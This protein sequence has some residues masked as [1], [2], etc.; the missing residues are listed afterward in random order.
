MANDNEKK[1]GFE[2]INLYDEETV[3]NAKEDKNLSGDSIADNGYTASSSDIT[4]KSKKK[5]TKDEEPF[6]LKKEIF[7]YIKIILCAIV[8]AL[9]FN[10]FIIVN[11]SVPS[12]SMES[13]IM[14]G[15]KISGNRLSYKFSEP[16]RGDIIIFKFPDNEEENYI[17]RIIG[18]P[19]DIIE[20]TNGIVYINGE[21]LDESYLPAHPYM[22]DFPAT[23]VPDDSYFMMGD[24]RLNSKDSRYWNNKFVSKDKIL[25]KAIFI[26]SPEFELIK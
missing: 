17:K 19:G 4:K 20:I 1:S 9:V 22:E 18:L 13:T 15:D 26:Y 14:K 8:I 11:A 10:N 21:A 7:S 3:N 5:R 12:S 6:D 23:V 16:E 24:N 25:A 2:Y